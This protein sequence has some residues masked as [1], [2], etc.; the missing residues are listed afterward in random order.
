MTLLYQ[1]FDATFVCLLNTKLHQVYLDA[2]DGFNDWIDD[3]FGCL[4]LTLE[5][6]K[7]KGG[8]LELSFDNCI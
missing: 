2:L 1:K 4:V 3:L 8:S 6:S 7:H 5:L